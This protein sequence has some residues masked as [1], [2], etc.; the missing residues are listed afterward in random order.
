M[1][2]LNTPARLSQNTLK[3]LCEIFVHDGYA[4]LVGL[5][6]RIKCKAAG[7]L[8]SLETGQVPAGVEGQFH[9]SG[10]GVYQ[11]LRSILPI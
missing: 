2:R 1:P 4:S 10:F 3:N 5:L 11:D 9:L 8:D 7:N 6:L